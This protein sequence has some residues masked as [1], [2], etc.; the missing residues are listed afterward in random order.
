MRTFFKIAGVFAVAG[1]LAACEGT[2]IERGALGAVG[3]ALTAEVLGTNVAGG[4]LI[5]GAAGVLCDDLTTVC[6]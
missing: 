2:D 1:T 4:A 5:G 6:R 3:G